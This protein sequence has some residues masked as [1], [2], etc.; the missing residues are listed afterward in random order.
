MVSFISL[1]KGVELNEDDEPFPEDS[2]DVET[3]TEVV[4]GPST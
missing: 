2:A 4:R 1:N 3:D